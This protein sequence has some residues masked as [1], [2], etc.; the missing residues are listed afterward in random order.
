VYYCWEHLLRNTYVWCL[1]YHTTQIPTHPPTHPPPIQRPL[2]GG[3]VGVF[4]ENI[5]FYFDR[6]CVCGESLETADSSR[7]AP[8]CYV[9]L[10]IV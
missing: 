9:P 1:L 4:L 5:R 2:M 7:H 10:C 8:A 6:F 3:T